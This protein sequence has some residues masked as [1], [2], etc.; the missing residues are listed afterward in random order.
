MS[1][2]ACQSSTNDVSFAESSFIMCL[3]TVVSISVHTQIDWSWLVVGGTGHVARISTINA[4]YAKSRYICDE[5][6][7]MDLE[8]RRNLQMHL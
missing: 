5:Y 8:G 2:D 4:S 6:R 7:Y 3:D 1:S